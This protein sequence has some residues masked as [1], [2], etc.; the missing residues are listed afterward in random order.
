MFMSTIM[1]TIMFFGHEQ[2]HKHA[3]GHEQE[4]EREMTMNMAGNM[5]KGMT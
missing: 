5:G 4:H 2:E 1:E 3:H